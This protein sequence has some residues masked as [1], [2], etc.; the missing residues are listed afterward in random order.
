MLCNSGV[1]YVNSLLAHTG[2]WETLGESAPTLSYQI[3]IKIDR[4]HSARVLFD[5]GSNR[6]LFDNT[7]AAE[8]DL[9][10]RD[11]TINLNVAGGGHETIE[12]KIFESDLVDRK[13][14]SMHFGDMELIPLL[15]H[16][17]LLTSPQ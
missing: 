4:D 3:D 9:I 11:A 7:F 5:S 10:K 1:D 17:K 6:V 14:R 16:K 13:G 15:N 8:N 2:D 12:T